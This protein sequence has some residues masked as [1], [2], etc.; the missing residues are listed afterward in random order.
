MERAYWA[1]VRNYWR[2][3]FITGCCLLALI[4]LVPGLRT[5][6]GFIILWATLAVVITVPML[7]ILITVSL[8]RLDSIAPAGTLVFSENFASGHSEKLFFGAGASRVLRIAVD[9]ESL[10]IY[11]PKIFCWCADIFDLMHKV[12]LANI[13]SCRLTSR[14]WVRVCWSPD[15]EQRGILLR[16]QRAGDIVKAI[17]SANRNLDI[18]PTHA[19]K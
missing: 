13:T 5:I 9:H 1:I 16:L 3:N 10:Y 18:G 11:Q 7:V 19:S 8:K 12:P 6:E 17:H 2:A 4:A 14:G 15:H